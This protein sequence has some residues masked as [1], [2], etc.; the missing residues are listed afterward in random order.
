NNR[1]SLRHE[2]LDRILIINEHHLRQLLTTYLHHVTTARPHQTL[3]QL[4][5]AQTETHPP[6]GA[7]LTNHQAH[8]RPILNE[9][10]N[11]DQPAA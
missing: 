8:R 9:L 3:G 5:P 6:H 7:N 10:T 11:E 4:A 1:H 2:L